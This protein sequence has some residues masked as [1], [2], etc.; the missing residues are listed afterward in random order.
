MLLQSVKEPPNRQNTVYICSAPKPPLCKGRWLAEGKTEGLLKWSCY[1]RRFDLL[2]NSPSTVSIYA[3]ECE[4]LA[5]DAS[6]TF[7]SLSKTRF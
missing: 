2:R 7:A 3:D 6:L 5:F 1:A 4:L